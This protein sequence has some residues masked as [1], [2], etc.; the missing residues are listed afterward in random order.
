[1][2]W[3]RNQKT[4]VK[5]LFGYGIFAIAIA[6]V[7][8]QG[9]A[10]LSESN[11]LLGN[12]YNRQMQGLSAIQSARSSLLRL[13]RANYQMLFDHDPEELSKDKE[14]FVQASDD[15][16]RHLNEADTLFVTP[17]GKLLLAQ[18]KTT[19]DQVRSLIEE[20]QRVASANDQTKTQA[21][22][23][24]AKAAYSSAS[25]AVDR[26]MVFK[27]SEAAARY[28]T[29]QETYTQT[30][31]LIVVISVFSVLIAAILGTIIAQM[32]SKPLG[33]MVQV[34]G[35]LAQ[36]NLDQNISLNSSDETG[37]LAD[38]FRNMIKSFSNTVLSIRESSTQVSATAQQLA[39]ASQ[40]ISSGA[41]E[42]AASLEETSASLEE[43]TATVKQNADSA[44]QANQLAAGARDAAEKG[45]TV[46]TSA[47]SAMSE[48]NAASSRIAEII[49]T[50][51][52]IAFQTNLLALNAAVEAA[53]AGEQGRGFAV[54]ASEVRSLAQ[55]SASAAKE[56]KGLIQ[57]SVRKVE[58][59][60]ELVNNSGRTLGE[61]VSSVKRVTD[62]VAEIS[63]ASQEQAAGV[64]QV[65][66]AM[67]QM[68]QVTQ[69]NSAQTEEMSS[70][71]EQLSSTAEELQQLISIFVIGSDESYAASRNS[72]PAIQRSRPAKLKRA[73][74]PS[75]SSQRGLLALAH[76]T[77]SSN[78]GFEDF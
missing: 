47:V 73:N 21:V 78:D 65:A 28:K 61:I 9:V 34:A 19:V 75:E 3:F 59:G 41:Q 44:R 14:S 30:S 77:N 10:A 31:R 55:R 20:S 49:T 33:E 25:Q 40:E 43:I 6:V 27:E 71:A 11:A 15:L 76:Q 22:I 35:A 12:V 7:G 1:M 42:Q 64:E 26:A 72:R 62:I 68:D 45:G 66:K 29:S 58:N 52:E 23:R 48:I 46:M 67:A 32:I 16:T 5:L 17:E 54:V 56:I 51:D 36:G 24:Q 39:S 37:K 18:V 57:D 50:I 8:Y 2:N 69:A 70:T 63:A 53:R 4:L 74:T 60:T 38:A 13:D